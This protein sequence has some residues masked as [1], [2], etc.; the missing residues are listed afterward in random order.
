VPF[1]VHFKSLTPRRF[2]SPLALTP[3]WR[4][5][6]ICFLRMNV[7]VRHGT[8]SADP[9]ECNAFHR[10][11]MHSDRRWLRNRQGGMPAIRKGRRQGAGRRPQRSMAIIPYVKFH[12]EVRGSLS[13]DAPVNCYQD[14]EQDEQGLQTNILGVI[15]R[16]ACAYQACP[17]V[18]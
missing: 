15:I 10:K 8:N 2:A 4:S 14:C 3:L 12:Q 16:N 17:R 9:Q 7:S 1:Q 5:A 13:Y 6:S 18:G 11:S